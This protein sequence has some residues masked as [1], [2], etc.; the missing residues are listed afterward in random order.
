MTNCCG[1]CGLF[2]GPDIWIH[3]YFELTGSFFYIYFFFLQGDALCKQCFFSAFEAEVHQTITDAGLFRRGERVA[4][5][6]S[7]G[8]GIDTGARLFLFY[9]E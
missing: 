2:Q 7:G 1:C 4:V 5:G 9:S 3:L 8:K 6:A